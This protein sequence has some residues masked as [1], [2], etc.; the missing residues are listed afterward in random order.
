[1]MF[2]VAVTVASI[3]AAGLGG[4]RVVRV[5]LIRT[6][7]RCRGIIET[8][9]WWE[10]ARE[11]GMEGRERGVGIMLCEVKMVMRERERECVSV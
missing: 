11:R 8:V 5:P 3:Q 6:F 1:M 9:C 4:A 2:W 10:V 7:Q